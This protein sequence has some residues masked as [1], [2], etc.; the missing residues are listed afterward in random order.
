MVGQV[1]QQLKL[2]Q[3]QAKLP[4]PNGYRTGAV[5]DSQAAKFRPV[6]LQAACIGQ[7]LLRLCRHGDGL[8]RGGAAAAGDANLVGDDDL[9]L[10]CLHSAGFFAGNRR[11]SFPGK[12]CSHQA[13]GGVLLLSRQNFVFHRQVPSSFFWFATSLFCQ[14]DMN[15]P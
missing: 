8:H 12:S 1:G 2:L 14:G 7:Q 4:L 11:K 5:A 6:H 10:P 3:R 9:P 15:N 13:A